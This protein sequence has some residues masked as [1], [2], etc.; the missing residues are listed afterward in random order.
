LRKEGGNSD[1]CLADDDT[2]RNLFIAKPAKSVTSLK[3][4]YTEMSS[5]QSSLGSSGKAL[6][7]DDE[8]EEYFESSSASS[9]SD[10]VLSLDP[11]FRLFQR[12]APE[13]FQLNSEEL[14]RQELGGVVVY[15]SYA[16]IVGN[17]HLQAY[18]ER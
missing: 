10:R 2:A 6:S 11:D 1:L 3:K 16:R 9:M 13:T 12:P 15:D 18:Y 4:E 7:E 5:S 8:D 17:S 14:H